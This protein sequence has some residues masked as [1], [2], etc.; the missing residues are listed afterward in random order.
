[1]QR[2]RCLVVDDSSTSPTNWRRRSPLRPTRTGGAAD[3]TGGGDAVSF[4]FAPEQ[5]G[6]THATQPDG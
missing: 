1:M 6:T 4:T 3:A 5:E 2:R